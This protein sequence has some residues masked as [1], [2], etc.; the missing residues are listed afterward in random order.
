MTLGLMPKLRLPSPISCIG[1]PC[2]LDLE[3]LSFLGCA[4][5]FA[6]IDLPK[7]RLKGAF[8]FLTYLKL[9]LLSQLIA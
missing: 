4:L 3:T 6:G 9:S 1:I 8:F 2:S 5:I 7:K